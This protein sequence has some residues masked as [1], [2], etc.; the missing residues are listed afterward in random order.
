MK[1]WMERMAAAMKTPRAKKRIY[2]GLCLMLAGW[3]VFRFMAVS[4]E[5]RL[6]VFNPARSVA[7]DGMPVNVLRMQQ[8]NETLREPI[9][10]VNNRALVS[11]SRVGHFQAGQKIGAGTIVSVASRIDLDTGMYPVRT[12]GVADGLNYAEYAAR[13]YFIPK[14]AVHNNTVFVVDGGRAVARDVT[15][16]RS[17]DVRVLVTD[18]LVDGDIVIVSRVADGQKVRIKK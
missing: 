8:T 10:V 12:R 4:A 18:G 16:G 2:A 17:D 1:E 13:G 5:N 14:E 3:F 11:G 15:V 9:S 7:V 6:V